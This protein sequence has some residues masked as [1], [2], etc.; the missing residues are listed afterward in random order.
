MTTGDRMENV[1]VKLKAEETKFSSLEN[2][3]PLKQNMKLKF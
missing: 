2:I 3:E 1:N